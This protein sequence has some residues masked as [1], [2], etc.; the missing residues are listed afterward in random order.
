[1]HKIYEDVEYQIDMLGCIVS[2]LNDKDYTTKGKHI[3][4][5]GAHVRHTIEYLQILIESNLTDTIDY[6]ERKRDQRIETNRLYAKN[7]LESL[8]ANL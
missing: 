7:Q 3:S 6:S 5:I 4:S 8:K 2:N 1:M